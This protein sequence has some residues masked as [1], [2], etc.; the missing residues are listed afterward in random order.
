MKK[1]TTAATALLE[2]VEAADAFKEA[3]GRLA[4]V[5]FLKSDKGKDATAITEAASKFDDTFGIVTSAAVAAHLGITGDAPAVVML[6]TFDEPVVVMEGTEISA[7]KVLEFAET[8]SKALLLPFSDENAKII[9]ESQFHVLALLPAEGEHEAL[10]DAMRAASKAMRGKKMQFVQVD[11][12]APSNAGVLN[13]FGATQLAA[14]KVV[15]FVSG[16]AARKFVLEGEITVDALTAFAG[17][18]LDLSATPLTMSAAPPEN[19]DGPLIEVV[20]STLDE[21]VL[22][23]TKDVLLEVYSPQCGHCKALEP[24]YNKLARRFADIPSVVIAKM[25]ATANEQCVPSFGQLVIACSRLRVRYP[26][27][28]SQPEDHSGRVPH[29]HALPGA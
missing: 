29:D 19:N 14:P 20:G 22:D 4:M 21:I 25:D 1:K 7:E 3:G 6:R 28:S 8:Y 24:V 11:A 27:P 18:V 26:L 10:L 2:S 15:G 16:D 17:Q 5:A 9:F 12:S 23:P 13:Y